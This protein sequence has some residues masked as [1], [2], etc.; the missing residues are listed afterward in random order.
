MP[1]SD[2]SHPG[3]VGISDILA[4][5]TDARPVSR[6]DRLCDLV[7]AQL[8]ARLPRAASVE[9][10]PVH[11]A[12]YDMQ[13]RDAAI[14]VLANNGQFDRGSTPARAALMETISII[15][16]ILVRALRGDA[17]APALIE[18]VRLALQGVSLGGC[19]AIQPIG[20]SLVDR[21]EGVLRFDFEFE[22]RLPA[23]AGSEHR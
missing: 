3:G 20:W 21:D 8:A 1:P 17:G 11:A 12:Q 9:R 22:T 6:L 18:D 5:I 16:V 4:T 10:F 15:V 23:V 14:L 7:E 13:G 2:P 19:S